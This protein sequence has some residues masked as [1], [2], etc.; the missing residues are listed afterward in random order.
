MIPKRFISNISVADLTIFLYNGSEIHVVGL[1]NHRRLQGSRFHFFGISET[2]LVADEVFTE[3]LMP[4]LIDVE[5]SILVAE[6]RPL[7]KGNYFYELFKRGRSEEPEYSKY[8]AYHWT[9]DGILTEEQII[10]AKRS[11]SQEDYDRE[12]NASF[13]TAQGS[14]YHAYSSDNH[15][16]RDIDPTL[17]IYIMCDFNSTEKPM[18]W[19]VG[20]EIL[21]HNKRVLYLAK[22]YVLPY[23]NTY[24]MADIVLRDISRLKDPKV[25]FFGDYAGY[26]HSSNSSTTDWEIIETKFEKYLMPREPMMIYPVKSV[27][28][29]IGATNKMLKNALGEI[30]LYVNP[31]TCPNLIDDWT[32]AEWDKSGMRL[33]E[34]DPKRGHAC[35]AVDYC[36]HALYPTGKKQSVTIL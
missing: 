29:S 21:Y 15:L 9:A 23:T 11:L 26:S 10:E 33:N 20:Q 24:Q 8:M 36:T 30:S 28:D 34:N 32:L 25:R 27:R 13:E 22:E 18:S 2:Q 1:E 31:K 4:T 17:P 5:E 3:T 14:P 19:V 12:F 16:I 7:Y 35:R 6:G